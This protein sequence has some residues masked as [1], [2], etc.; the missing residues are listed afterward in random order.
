MKEEKGRIRFFFG[1]KYLVDSKLLPKVYAQADAVR[2]V[3]VPVFLRERTFFGKGL[4]DAV[5]APSRLAAAVDDDD[6]H[7]GKR[8]WTLSFE[9]PKGSYATVLFKRL[10]G[11]AVAD[12]PH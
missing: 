8:K 9:L 3:R 2:L 7:A 4:R 12:F 1:K 6:L 11:T 5:V 10:F